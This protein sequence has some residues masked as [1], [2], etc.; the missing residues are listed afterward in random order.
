M[1]VMASIHCIIKEIFYYCIMLHYVQ[2]I[3]ISDGPSMTKLPRVLRAKFK[4][5]ERYSAFCVNLSI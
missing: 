3:I 4:K 2:R 5:N 1:Y